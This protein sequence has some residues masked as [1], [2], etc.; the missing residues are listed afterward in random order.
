[1]DLQLPQDDQKLPVLILSEMTASGWLPSF[2]SE[3]PMTAVTQSSHCTK[4]FVKVSATPKS[5]H[6]S[7]TIT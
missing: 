4:A 2:T 3:V 5:C 6:W 1:M 7:L